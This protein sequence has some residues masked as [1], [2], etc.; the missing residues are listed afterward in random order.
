[1]QVGNRKLLK[2]RCFSPNLPEKK[3]KWAHKLSICHIVK[4]SSPGN[5]WKLVKWPRVNSSLKTCGTVRQSR[6]SQNSRYF[7]LVSVNIAI[8]SGTATS[9]IFGAGIKLDKLSPIINM[10]KILH[11]ASKTFWWS[12]DLSVMHIFLIEWIVKQL[13]TSLY[14][15]Q[16]THKYAMIYMYL[17]P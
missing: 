3:C 13:L 6:L 5:S 15:K 2:W 14:L 8:I 16:T 4:T 11:N 7:I 12:A 9:P 10:T 17:Q 1:M